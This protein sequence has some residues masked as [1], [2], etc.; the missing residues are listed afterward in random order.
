QDRERP[1]LAVAADAG[2]TFA[3][4]GRARPDLLPRA[5]GP[6]GRLLRPCRRGDRADAAGLALRL[7]L[8]AAGGAARVPPGRPAVPGDDRARRG[9]VPPLPAH[10]LRVHLR[11]RGRARVSLRV[12]DLLA[13]ARRFAPAPRNGP[14][15]AR[16]LH[17]PADPA[18]VDHPYPEPP[19]DRAV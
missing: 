14:A 4:F 19:S 11:S 15:R 8:R 1:G 13:R 7:S 3:S 6:G 10:R 18:S 17:E 5:F 12:H 9:A 16:I 2:P